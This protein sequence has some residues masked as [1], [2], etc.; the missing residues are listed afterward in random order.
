M[1]R[2]A[3]CGRS[4]FAILFSLKMRQ[5]RCSKPHEEVFSW[6]NTTK[7]LQCFNTFPHEIWNSV[8]MLFTTY[9]HLNFW[10]SLS[11]LGLRM[12]LQHAS[13][14]GNLLLDVQHSLKVF[15]R[16]RISYQRRTPK[17]PI[18]KNKCLATS[19]IFFVHA[20]TLLFQ[21]SLVGSTALIKLGCVAST[22]AS[23]VKVVKTTPQY[24]NKNTIGCFQRA[25][26]TIVE[27]NILSLC[28]T[29]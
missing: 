26:C 25:S 21:T 3:N 10:H 19:S 28:D 22:H 13:F 18:W 14:C 6:E 23:E 5:K 27:V 4:Y 24:K 9:F 8:Q 11:R 1:K 20:A 2:N 17:K 29:F 12:W 16:K 7:C 15:S